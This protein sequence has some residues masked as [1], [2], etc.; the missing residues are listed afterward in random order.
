MK[1]FFLTT[2]MLA[3]V[4]FPLSGTSEDSPRHPSKK[5]LIT[6]I[7]P[8]NKIYH[9]GWTDLNKNGRMDVYEDPKADIETR[10]TDLLS[11]MTIEEK[12]CQMVTLYGYKRILEDDLPTAA[13][14]ERLWKDGIGAIDE[15]LNGLKPNANVWPA[16]R[17]AWALNE[18]QR[19]FIEETRLGIPADFTNEGIGGVESYKSTT[20]PTQLG[21]GSAWDKEL[22]RQVGYITGRE[23]RLLGYT[24]VYAPILDVLRDQRWGRFSDNYGESPFLVAELGIQMVKG[25]QTDYQVAST[26]KHYAIHSNNKGARECRARTDPQISPREVENI[27]MYPYRRIIPETNML[28]VM[29]SY[30]DYDGQPIESSHYWLTDKLRGEFGFKGYVV[31]DSEAVDFVSTK[32]GTADDVKDA[33]RQ[34][35]EAGLN[36]RC[37]FQT[38]DSYVLP[39]RELV[40]EGKLSEQVINDRVRDILRVKFLVG[41]FDHPYQEDLKAADDEVNSAANN[42]V[43]LRAS[44]ESIILLKNKGGLLPLD[45]NKVKQV[46]VVGPNATD[47]T[48]AHGRYSP[49]ASTATSVLTGLQ[50]KG[51][52]KGFSVNYAKGCDL[53]DPHWPESEIFEYEMTQAEKDSIRKA[54][55]LVGQSDVA[56]VVLGDQARTCAE[57]RSRTSLDLP[58][59]Q[60]QLLKAVYATGKPVV[61]VLINGRPLTINWAD[62][63]VP[64]IVEAWFP[65]AHGGT[66]IA[67]VIG[68]EYNPGGKLTVTFPK[69]VGQIPFNFPTKP[70]AQS[71]TWG[72]L[73]LKGKQSGLNGALYPF[74]YGLSYTTFE[75]SD[76]KLSAHEVGQG[77]DITATCTIRN[78]GNR[79]GDEV[80]QLY[81]RDIIS[82]LTTYEKNLRGF[83]RVRLK[84]GESKEIS[85]TLR[86]RDLELLNAE[87]K[88]VVEPGDFKVMIGAS[89]EDIRLCDIFTVTG[90]GWNKPVAGPQKDIETTANTGQAVPE[91]TDSQYSTSWTG[92]TGDFLEFSL[93]GGRDL[94]NTTIA[95]K[96]RSADA[97]FEIQV[98]GGGETFQ[99]VFAGKFNA[100]YT[101][102]TYS[103]KKQKAVKWRLLVTKGKVTIAEINF[104]DRANTILR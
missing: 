60:E 74:G 103:F 64:A 27:H 42:E 98:S 45:W 20:F 102:A 66:A 2:A 37:D 92:K 49:Q 56:I 83:E 89:S 73:G 76:L 18:I 71:D 90:S 57:D 24:N 99:K 72:G 47:T 68:G 95:I 87:Q 67:E 7:H 5:E 61:L 33:I 9:K 101:D 31:S 86:P 69:T 10:I 15:Q 36:I 16:S 54:V 50:N 43:A 38:P 8:K 88:W 40:K 30:N 21:L 75:Y 26:A 58:G 14:K 80:V 23:G 63:Y 91:V 55:D 12:T 41:L 22:V 100:A 11:Q 35:V 17:H 48:F 70:F 1:A 82:S 62:K 85:F 93:K 39:L 13:W 79:E 97:A 51:R 28:G 94:K 84:P 59:R 44:R 81:T 96:E 104:N 77:Q 19:F 65:G 46:A 3:M 6:Y 25:M 52:E 29:A 78:T 53:V 34:S 4:L 32:H